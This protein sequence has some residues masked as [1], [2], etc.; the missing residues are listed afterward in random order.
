MVAVAG[1]AAKYRSPCMDRDLDHELDR[2]LKLLPQRA[3]T[4]A[5]EYA[6]IV[7]VLVLAIA[8]S[9]HGLA[10]KMA[11]ILDWSAGAIR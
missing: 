10:G 4:T 5:T 2:E 6:L 9:L 7:T 1:G 3:E 11:A 8:I